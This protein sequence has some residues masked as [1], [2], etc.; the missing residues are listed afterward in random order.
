MFPLMTDEEMQ[1]ADEATLRQR[2]R[3]LMNVTSVFRQMRDLLEG[4]KHALQRV[5]D[6]LDRIERNTRKPARKQAR[7]RRQSK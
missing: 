6:T 1:K 4:H 2:V 3:D 5:S 7:K